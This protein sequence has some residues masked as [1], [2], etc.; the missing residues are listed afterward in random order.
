MLPK[1]V[2]ALFYWILRSGPL[3][4]F[5]ADCIAWAFY[6]TVKI[7]R[8]KPR[9][10]IAG[11]TVI[12][13]KH[14]FIFFG[15]PKVASRSFYNIFVVDKCDEFEIEWYEK[16]N[17][18]F[19]A[20][21]QYPDYYCFSLVRNPWSRIVSCYNS[22]IADNIIGKRA[23][24]LSFYRGLK[25]GMAFDDFIAWLGSHEG[26]DDI[27]DRHWIS[28]HQFL[29]DAHGKSLCDFIGRYE[30]LEADWAQVCSEIG[31]DV[32]A[33]PQR[34]FVSADGVTKDPSQA[35]DK[36]GAGAKYT[37]YQDKFDQRTR[38]IIAQRYAKDIEMFDYEF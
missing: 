23:R 1:P 8:I 19:D 16:R 18:F 4:R 36:T 2:R 20:K 38:E 35:K 21:A 15:I 11:L 17:A 5:I 22:K 13:H 6:L 3:G 25:G 14:K 26:R 30:N 32:I 29:C 33:L 31:I 10:D 12:S 24:I 9:Q 34:G 28:Q 37:R 27:A 7:L